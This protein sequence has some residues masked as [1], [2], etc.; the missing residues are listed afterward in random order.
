M[1]PDLEPDPDTQDLDTQDTDTQ[2][3]DTQ[4]TDTQDPHVFGPPGPGSGSISTR[5][6]S[7]SGFF[8]NQ[9]KLVR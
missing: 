2:D 8:Y 3:L 4:D 1:V 5:Y 9:A 7:G 6:R